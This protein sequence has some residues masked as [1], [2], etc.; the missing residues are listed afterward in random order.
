M[1]IWLET[2]KRNW[3]SHPSVVWL[4]SIA[5][6]NEQTLKVQCTQTETPAATDECTYIAHWAPLSPNEPHWVNNKPYW[7]P[8]SCNGLHQAP[9]ISTDCQWFPMKPTEPQWPRIDPYWA[10]MFPIELQWRTTDPHWVLMTHTNL[11]L[12]SIYL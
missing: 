5:S 1:F 8:L 6:V 4:W 10:L 3:N 7:A 9:M 2:L 12:T 11:Q